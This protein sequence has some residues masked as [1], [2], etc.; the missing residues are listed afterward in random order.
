M[1]QNKNKLIQLFIGNVY[2]AIV[3]EILEKAIDLEEIKNKYHKELRTSMDIAKYYRDKI[4]P[5]D[6]PL[7]KDAKDIKKDIMSRVNN[8]LKIRISKGYKNIDLDS[9][10]STVNKFLKE[11]KV[12][13]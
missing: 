4:N 3:H 10:E 6:K 11:L 1:A 9:V 7:L 13:E 8:E 5:V 2:N 12:I